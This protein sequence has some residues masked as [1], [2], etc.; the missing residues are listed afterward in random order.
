VHCSSDFSRFRHRP[1]ALP[2]QSRCTSGGTSR[3]S[4][5]GTS[6]CSSGGTSRCSSGRSNPLTTM[7]R[8][9]ERS[10]RRSNLLEIYVIASGATSSRCSSG[11]T[12]RCSSGRERERKVRN[13]YSGAIPNQFVLSPQVDINMK[14]PSKE[15]GIP[16][17][18]NC[19]SY[20]PSAAR[21]FRGLAG[22][23]RP[24]VSDFEMGGLQGGRPS[25]VSRHPSSVVRLPSPVIRCPL[26]V[27]HCLYFDRSKFTYLWKKQ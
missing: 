19:S 22:A 26:S 25:S 9:E 4:S 23:I 6:W 21:I 24:P 10:V 8:C 20:F 1:G 15:K 5:G 2:A 3:C 14:K 18:N 27:V 16:E 17:Q 12:S 7:C 11:G 13:C